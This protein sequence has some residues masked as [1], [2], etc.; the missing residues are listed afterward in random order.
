[1]WRHLAANAL[2]FFVVALFLIA[3]LV[4]WGQ[5]RWAQPGPL[6][7]AICFQ[8]ESDSTMRQVSRQ[9]A[10]RGAVS[11]DWIFR[12]GSD[13]TDRTARLKAGS[14][15]IPAS[16]SM[17]DVSRVIT[18]SGASTCGT[19]VVYLVGIGASSARVRELDPATGDLEQ[20]ASFDFT[21]D[22]PVP[23]EYE[24]A[25][26]EPGT[27][28]WVRVIEGT[29]SWQ[30]AQALDAIDILEGEVG[31][32]PAEGSL[33][34][35][36]YDIEP[37]TD[38]AAVLDRMRSAQTRILAEAWA[39]RAE[40]LPFDTPEE[41]LTLASIVEKETAIPEERPVVASVLVNRIEDGMRLQFDP[42][43]IYGITRGQGVLDR[44][45]RRSDIE[46]R[47]ERELHGEVAYNTYVVDGLPA[48]PIANPGRES[49]AAVLNPEKTEALYFVA[50]G[51]GGHVFAN[52]LAEHNANVRKWYALRR[53]RGEM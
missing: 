11:S 30:V 18:G 40:N 3:G 32:V 27:T 43:I 48:G 47:T 7:Q 38:V 51:T 19:E 8:V 52:T 6:A 41:A 44:P 28:Y 17:E 39:A 31:E 35:N 4:A 5:S 16:A 24:A 25:R 34:P 14:F 46:G 49:I 15:L 21:A 26:A 9:L 10:E 45:I 42:T 53:Q 12:A 37:G 29:T 50:D 20:T 1:M 23:P 33:A 13:Y 22:E 36:T 2:T